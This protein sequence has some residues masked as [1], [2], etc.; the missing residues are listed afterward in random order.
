MPV[1]E[2]WVTAEEMT[3]TFKKAKITRRTGSFYSKAK[4][5]ENFDRGKSRWCP[6]RET[7]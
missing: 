6:I 4:S 1:A 2:R 5:F 3:E 7:I